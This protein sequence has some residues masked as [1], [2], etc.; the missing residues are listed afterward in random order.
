M[1][2]INSLNLRDE[3]AKKNLRLTKESKIE[4]VKL[5]GE[6][7]MRLIKVRKNLLDDFKQK[8]VKLLRKYHECFAWIMAN[9]LGIDLKVTYHWLAIDPNAK[10]VQQKK[11][12][13]GHERSATIKVEVD[14]LLKVGFIKEVPY[15]T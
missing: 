11:R 7:D 2:L 15:T 6:F 12:H 1:I 8:L 14:K 4:E 13:H 9:M 3:G 5:F 10:H